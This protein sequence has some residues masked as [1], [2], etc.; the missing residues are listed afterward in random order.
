MFWW[1][2]TYL[3]FMNI[4]FYYNVRIIYYLVW[5]QEASLFSCL[6]YYILFLS[7]VFCYVFMTFEHLVFLLNICL[8]WLNMMIILTCSWLFMIMCFKLNYFNNIWLVVCTYIWY[9]VLYFLIIHICFI[10]ILWMKI[11]RASCRERV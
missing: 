6:N 7:L 4:C 10:W 8:V 9:C 3:L 1:L 5:F 11:G 2:M